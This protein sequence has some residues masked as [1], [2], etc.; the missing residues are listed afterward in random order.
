MT[1]HD[2]DDIQFLLQSYSYLVEVC[3]AIK[4]VRRTVNNLNEY[5]NDGKPIFK[6]VDRLVNLTDALEER[7]NYI[8]REFE[9]ENVSGCQ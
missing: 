7:F 9:L 6:A 5:N 1:D 3:S 4:E 2:F 8:K